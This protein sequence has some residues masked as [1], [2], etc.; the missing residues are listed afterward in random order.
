MPP[1]T[2]SWAEAYDL[3]SKLTHWNQVNIAPAK[4]Y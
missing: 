2:F 1:S 4:G 3:K